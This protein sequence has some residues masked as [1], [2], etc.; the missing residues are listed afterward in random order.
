MPII[1]YRVLDHFLKTL[2]QF[3]AFA[4]DQIGAKQCEIVISAIACM[5]LPCH[6]STSHRTH[7]TKWRTSERIDAHAV[8][9]IF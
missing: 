2:N 9:N 6:T 3:S 7:L 4:L 5:M 8:V 1:V